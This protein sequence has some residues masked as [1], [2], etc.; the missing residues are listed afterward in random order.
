ML[1]QSSNR[2]LFVMDERIRPSV[3]LLRVVFR[4]SIMSV[5]FWSLYFVLRFTTSDYSF[6]VFIVFVDLVMKMLLADY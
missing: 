3:F 6:G 2:P 1:L 5:F 4:S